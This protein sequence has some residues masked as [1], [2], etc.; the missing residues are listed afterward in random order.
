MNAHGATRRRLLVIDD[1][2]VLREM[3]VANLEE[4]GY[5]VVAAPNGAEAMPILRS[6]AFD[7]ILVDLVMPRMDGLR[8]L[9]WLRGEATSAVPALVFTG[10][11]D[12]RRDIRQEALAAGA[13]ELIFKPVDIPDLLAALARLFGP[14]GGDGKPGG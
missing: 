8:F 9:K 5:D 7:A 12:S 13:T 1:D 14:G 4:E 3:L 2:E 10:S 6:G 11:F